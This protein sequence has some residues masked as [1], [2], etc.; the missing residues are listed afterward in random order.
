MLPDQEA[1]NLRFSEL[2]GGHWLVLNFPVPMRGAGDGS[3]RGRQE[4][5]GRR[6]VGKGWL[7]ETLC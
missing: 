6:Y 2:R 5:V 1:K 7:V 3:S 4:E